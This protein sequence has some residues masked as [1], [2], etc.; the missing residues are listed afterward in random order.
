MS[1]QCS[2]LLA[3]DQSKPPPKR[4]VHNDPLQ[5]FAE[6]SP[7]VKLKALWIDRLP[8]LAEKSPKAIREL[9]LLAWAV[10]AVVLGLLGK[11]W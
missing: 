6:E 11:G 5:H 1:G 2:K 8:E 9:R 7:S 10:V 4:T 3:M